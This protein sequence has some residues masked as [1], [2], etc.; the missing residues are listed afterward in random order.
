MANQL[1]HH[2]PICGPATAT[3]RPERTQ[4]DEGQTPIAG[5]HPPGVPVSGI[6]ALHAAQHLVCI[7]V[8]AGIDRVEVCKRI[9]AKYRVEISG[10]TMKE[11]GADVDVA[12]GVAELERQLQG[13]L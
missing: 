1:G 11:L 5:N 7:E 2:L 8:P 4:F 12:A 3:S 10:S 6:L 9:S 13:A